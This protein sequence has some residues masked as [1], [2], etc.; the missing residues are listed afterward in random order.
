MYYALWL[1]VIQ[2]SRSIRALIRNPKLSGTLIHGKLGN[3]YP[4]IGA[5][6]K[7]WRSPATLVSTTK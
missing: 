4:N 1:S 5:D 3:I 2:A 7:R 6:E